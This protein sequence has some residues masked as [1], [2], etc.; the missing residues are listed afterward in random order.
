MTCR[1]GWRQMQARLNHTLL[2][3]MCTTE[4]C[5]GGTHPGGAGRQEPHVSER[6]CRHINS[7]REN[8]PGTT[9]QAAIEGTEA[10]VWTCVVCLGNYSSRSGQKGDGVRRSEEASPGRVTGASAGC[11]ARPPSPLRP[12]LSHLIEQ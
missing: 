11:K 1:M 3:G 8:K 9:F 2:G 10:E 4:L 7:R 12:A 6:F 5:G